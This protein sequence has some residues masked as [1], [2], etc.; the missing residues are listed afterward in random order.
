MENTFM[1][2]NI[3]EGFFDGKFVLCGIALGFILAEF[4]LASFVSTFLTKESP[5]VV[6]ITS[7]GDALTSSLFHPSFNPSPGL[8]SEPRVTST[9]FN[10]CS[11]DGVEDSASHKFFNRKFSAKGLK[12]VTG[13]MSTSLTVFIDSHC[14]D[15]W[16]RFPLQTFGTVRLTIHA[17]NY[18]TAT[19]D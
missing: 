12:G 16:R 19:L 18:L 10:N 5:A 15:E 8:A 13:A 9:V 14:P 17:A 3:L 6:F 7:S 11:C 1:G 4:L 2:G